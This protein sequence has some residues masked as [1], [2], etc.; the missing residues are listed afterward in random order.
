[1]T[2]LRH[3][4]ASA[5]VGRDAHAFDLTLPAGPPATLFVIPQA[6]PARVPASPPLHPQSTTLG[7]SVA[8]WQRG[9][10]IYVVAI[11]SDRLQDYQRLIKAS[12]AIAA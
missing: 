6:E 5:I 7:P 2:P 4:D 11:Q 1:V 12:P 10:V 3:R 9:N 8:Y